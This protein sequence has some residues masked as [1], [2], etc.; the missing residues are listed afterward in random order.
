M[1]NTRYIEVSSNYRNRNIWPLAAEFEIPIS[2]TGLKS[3]NDALDPVSLSMPIFSWTSNNLLIG[4]TSQIL[5]G[6]VESVN[7]IKYSSDQITFVIKTTRAVQQLKNYY[8]SLVI[9]DRNIT[10]RPTRRIINSYYLGANRTE[11]TLLF[12]YSDSFNL[13]DNITITDPSDFSDPNFPLIF[14]P[15]GAFQENAYNQYIL[16]NETCNQYR[17]IRHYDNSY[18]VIELDTSGSS[19]STYSSGP[20]TVGV[21]NWQITDNFSLRTQPP[22]IPILGG[23]NPVIVNT[24]T[25]GTKVI[26]TTENT[27]IITN[28]G[29]NTLSTVTNYYKNYFLRVLPYGDPNTNPTDIYYEYDPTVSNNQARRI[30]EYNYYEDSGAPGTYYGVFTVYPDFNLYNNGIGAS[31]EILPFSRDNFNPFVYTGSL[32]SQQEM[33]CYQVQ[34]STLTLPNATLAISQGGRIAFYP[35]V[36]VQLSNVSASG[37]GLKNIIYSNNPN[38]TNVIFRVPIYDVQNPLS[39]PFVRINGGS[40]PQTI[41]FKPNDNLYFK[42]TLSTGETF[43]TILEEWYSPSIPN[44]F[45]QITALF[46]FKRIG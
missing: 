26:N 6:T 12:P 8:N 1:S 40:M 36:Y 2:Q 33:V 45:S 42:V 18:D 5:T 37:A 24:I 10:N 15:N 30:T 17:P 38:A 19:S 3:K 14:V 21:G 7:P 39:T 28:P 41:K 20:I 22:T 35:F 25:V 11:L 29:G 23:V 34:L 31:I 16:Y 27:I 46:S 32:V 4:G 13:G 9:V 43:K 44:P